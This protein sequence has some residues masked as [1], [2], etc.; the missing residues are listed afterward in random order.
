[1]SPRPCGDNPTLVKRSILAGMQQS[2]K[3]PSQRDSLQ[4]ESTSLTALTYEKGL[5]DRVIGQAR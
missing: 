2:R 4:N 5:A 1:M 3:G